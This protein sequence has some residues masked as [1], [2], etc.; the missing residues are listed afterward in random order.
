MVEE[1]SEGTRV[2]VGDL[3]FAGRGAPFVQ[4]VMVR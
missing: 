4:S 3:R 1:T 2:S